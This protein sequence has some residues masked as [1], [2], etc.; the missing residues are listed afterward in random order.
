MSL[1]TNTSVA[2]AP[3]GSWIAS[4][5]FWQRSTPT[6]LNPAAVSSFSNVAD[7]ASGRPG[8]P[9]ATQHGPALPH[10]HICWARNRALAT[11]TAAPSSAD[12][13]WSPI[14]VHPLL[15]AYS[16]RTATIHA[17]RH[18]VEAAPND[19]MVTRYSRAQLNATEALRGVSATVGNQSQI[20][21]IKPTRETAV[22]SMTGARGAT[23]EGKRPV[24]T[25]QTASKS[26]TSS[27]R[28]RP[29]SSR[30]GRTSSCSGRGRSR[31]R[32]WSSSRRSSRR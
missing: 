7:G 15:V 18:F 2:R 9:L 27:P 21:R 10:S 30:R 26:C 22:A 24:F 6:T 13:C 23:A 17:R 11:T 25:S 1:S 5:L 31:R 16:A 14:S 28:T 19:R 20:E 8:F 29:C 3:D 12:S 4:L 32:R